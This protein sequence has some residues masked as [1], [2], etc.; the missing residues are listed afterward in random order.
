MTAGRAALVATIAAAA[1]AAGGLGGGGGAAGAKT[2][3]TSVG[4]GER[5]FRISV[6]RKHVLPGKVRFNV[7]NHGEDA[8]N[9][10]VIG[11][12]SGGPQRATSPEIK[13]N[14]Q[15]TLTVTLRTRGIYKL[16]CTLADHESRGMVSF[17]RVV[18]K[19]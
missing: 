12:G 13:A 10:R 17:V 18:K 8:H 3:T 5:E 7:T 19:L 11:P 15:D 1:A 14:A 9:L 6:Y 16:V 4:I 2:R